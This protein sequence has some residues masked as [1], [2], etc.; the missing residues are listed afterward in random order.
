MGVGRFVE[1]EQRT[2]GDLERPRVDRR[3]EPRERSAARDAVERAGRYALAPPHGNTVRIGDA[4]GARG[5][6]AE[7]GGRYAL[8]PR[9]GNTVRIGDAAAGAQRVERAT[10]CRTSGER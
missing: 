7:R 3:T 9:H 6:A 10:E 4:G 1:R 5:A 2:H 8:A